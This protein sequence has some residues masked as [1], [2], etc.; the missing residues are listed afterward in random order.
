MSTVAPFRILVPQSTIDDILARI[1]AYE[2][3]EMPQIEAGQ[4]RW[5]YGTD[6][7]Y[8]KTLCSYWVDAFDWR[9]SEAMLNTFP[10]FKATVDGQEIAFIHVKGSGDNPP[11]VVLTHG[12]PGSAFEFFEVIELLAHPAK[13][14]GAVDDGINLVIPSLPGYAFSG[15][16]R[17][18]VGPRRIA[19]LWDKLMREVLGVPRYI[20]QGGD[21]GAFVSGWLAYDHGI[22]KGGGCEAVHLNLYGVRPDARPET[23]AEKQWAEGSARWRERESAYSQL[24]ATKPQSLAYAMMES[25]VG[26]AAWIVEKFNAWSDR[27]AA[28]GSEHIENAFS[29]DQLLTNVMIYL[30]TRSFNTASWIYRGRLDEGGVFMA[31]G[32]R[33]RV[34]AGIAVF[35]K[36]PFAFPPRSMVEKGYPVVRWTELERGGHFAAMETGRVFADEVRAFVKQIRQS[37]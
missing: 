25:P 10:Q 18:P 26:V 35:P 6:R 8:L 4:D 2:W 17:R 9:K 30:V 36:E 19:A 37:G 12:W 1:R 5:A 34:P 24:Q 20:A 14:G 3:P 22:D 23:E 27:R 16:P 33:V 31:P 11:T 32:T 13:F 28:D 15:K 7:E 29:K 21:W